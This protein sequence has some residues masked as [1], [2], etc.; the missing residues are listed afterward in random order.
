M[1]SGNIKKFEVKLGKTGIIIVL[2]GMAVLLCLSFILGVGVGK[3]I[4][5]YP[6]KIASTP[7]QILAMFW[8]SAKV[9][10]AQK[11]MT[12]KETSPDKSS[13]DLTFHNT[14]TG[15]KTLPIQQLPSQE[16]RLADAAAAERKV[17]S[18]TPAALLPDGEAN[19]PNEAV[20]EKKITTGEKLLRE[21]KSK[22]KE[23]PA[24][25]N[26]AKALFFVQVASL[27]DKTK[28]NQIHKTVA[29][30]GYPSKVLKMDLKEKGIWYRVIAT[31]FDTKM[32]AQAAVDRISKKIKVKCVIRSVGSVQ[33]KNQ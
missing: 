14:L 13:M 28:A 1:G 23:E 20:Q 29:T 30:L 24:S 22:N 11:A 17:K 12:V 18:Q 27:K 5:T 7:Q 8:R 33:N 25:V 2:G 26:A 31:G 19:S 4:D 32:Q 21:N 15:Q 3:N 6:E 10:S 16:K 9:A